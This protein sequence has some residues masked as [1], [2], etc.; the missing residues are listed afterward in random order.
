MKGIAGRQTKLDG[1]L[2]GERPLSKLERWAVERLLRDF[3]TG[4]DRG[5]IWREN[6][7]VRVCGFFEKG[8]KHWQGRQFVGKAFIL[9]PWQSECIVAPLFGWY[10]EE[11]KGEPSRRFREV[12]VEVPRKNGKSVLAAGVG[13][14]AFVADGESGAEVY[15]V[16]T[17]RDQAKIVFRDATEMVKA[18]KELSQ[19]IQIYR[20][21]L[22]CEK[23][24][25]SFQPLSADYNTLDGLKTH[26][27]LVDELHRHR[28]RQLWDVIV[29]STGARRQPIIFAITTAGTDQLSVCYV[30]R[31]YVRRILDP[32]DPAEDD[33]ILGYVATIDEGDDWADPK[34]WAKANPNLGVSIEVE[35]V[36]KESKKA[37]ET[38]SYQNTFRRYHLDE[39]TQ[40]ETRWLDMGAWDA[41]AG[42]KIEP[43]AFKGKQCWAGLDL[44]TTIDLTAFVIC[45]ALEDGR[46][47]LWP[48]FWI[49]EYEMAE[50]E[51]RDRVPYR[52]WVREGWVHATPGNVVDYAFVR[53]RV[54]ELA[55]EYK[56]EEVAF[57][58]YNATHLCQE[59]QDEDGLK[60]TEH[61][62]GYLS[63]SPPAKEF[64]RLVKQGRIWHGGNPVLRWNADCVEITSD[65]AQNIK[66]V[67]PERER[68]GKRIDGIVAAI[69][70][71]GR[72]LTRVK[73]SVYAREGRGIRTL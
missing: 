57:D 51:R 2:K 64:E 39:W 73:R 14:F 19:R 68:S 27:A 37:R 34:S 29:T 36:A 16:A 7:A 25:S 35:Y 52:A 44:S 21:G 50:R 71:L 55:K 42:E 30:E 45:W 32:A 9:S 48:E 10:R 22:T 72:A 66:P 49:P 58:P 23:W 60:L 41:C 28:D 70:A 56:I 33:T 8:L 26:C 40:Q 6:E 12:Y 20:T 24:S 47:A 62:Q 59:L 1:L 13:L 63:M 5:L 4:A 67:K 38:P 43:G 69:M 65:P 18:S 15:C 17:K 54:R 31:D 3:E 11:A 46:Y 53:A 61:R